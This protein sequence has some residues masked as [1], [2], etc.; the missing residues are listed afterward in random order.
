MANDPND[1]L[2]DPSCPAC[3]SELVLSQIE[4][5]LRTLSLDL[6]VAGWTPDE[7]LDHVRQSVRDHRG[8][9]LLALVLL[10]DDSLRSEQSRP[11]AWCDAIDRLRAVSDSSHQD[12]APGWLARWLRTN[13]SY[14][15]SRE[16]ADL[17]KAFADTLADLVCPLPDVG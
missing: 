12:V 13:S 7:L 9:D 17:L 6:W 15:T 5:E 1:P 2:R 10:V 8:A 14:E 3:E 4:T 16:A 11:P